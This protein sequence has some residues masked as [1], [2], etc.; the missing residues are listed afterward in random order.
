[1]AGGTTEFRANIAR[2][3]VEAGPR[4]Y[5]YDNSTT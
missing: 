5:S 1:V 3:F 4:V 2:R